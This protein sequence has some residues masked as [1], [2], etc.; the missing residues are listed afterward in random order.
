MT[1]KNDEKKLPQSH[2]EPTGHANKEVALGANFAD[3]LR[4]GEGRDMNEELSEEEIKQGI[5]RV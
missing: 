5:R 2:L 4:R 3:R 1:D